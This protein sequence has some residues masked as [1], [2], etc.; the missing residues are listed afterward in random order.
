[1]IKF[2][3]YYRVSTARQGE[4][5]L[6]LEAQ[7]KAAK[8]YIQTVKDGEIIS[9]YTEVASGRKNDRVKLH[10]ALR[11]CK[12]TGATLLIAKLDRLSRDRR[13]L[14][15]LEESAVKF[16]CADMPEAN[17]LT[18]GMMA[19]LADYEAQLISE[20]TTAALQ[21]AKER[22]TILGNPKLDQFR[23]TDTAAANDARTKKS[24]E[25][26]QSIKE[27]IAEIEREYGE[28]SSRAMADKL[29]DAG[30]V[31]SRG[32][33]FSHVAVIRAKAS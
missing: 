18:I 27:V 25:Y 12:L 11:K 29:N 13:F 19:C 26:N 6:G 7:R 33:T 22:G 2:V 17:R 14:L 24:L 16:V 21:I 10:E 28:M 20:R 32:K 15:E 1:M 9:A 3:A 30:Y 31:T 23:N 4:S 8:N 5:G